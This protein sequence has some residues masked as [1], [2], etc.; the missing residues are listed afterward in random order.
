MPY[1]IQLF[2][3]GRFTMVTEGKCHFKAYLRLHHK[4]WQHFGVSR[5]EFL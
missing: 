1:T 3:C 4:K 2:L 5:E